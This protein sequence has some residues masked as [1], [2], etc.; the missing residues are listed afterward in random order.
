MSSGLPVHRGVEFGYTDPSG[1]TYHNTHTHT[2]TEY[3]LYSALYYA[4]LQFAANT[5]L[6]RNRHSSSAV[7]QSVATITLLF[8]TMFFLTAL[9]LRVRLLRE[10]S[11]P[12]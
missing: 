6:L 4:D 12:G 1:S 2:H 11:L 3:K 7:T 10:Q 5:C 9:R 8:L